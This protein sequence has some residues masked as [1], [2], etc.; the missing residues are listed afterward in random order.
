MDKD[1]DKKV[2]AL[3]P[4]FKEKINQLFESMHE[5]VSMLYE[6]A[7]HDEKTGLYNNKFFETMLEMEMEKAKRYQQKL[8]LLIIDIDFFKRINDTYGHMK[9]DELL[10][11]LAKVFM[12][13]A[14][15]SDVV[16]RFG[17]EEFII[18]LPETDL[19]KAKKF[20]ERL[21]QATKKNKML[22]GHE[23]TFSGGLT[24]YK[25]G[26]TKLKFKERAD[27][28]LYKAKDTGRDKIVAV[29]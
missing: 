29:K 27:K 8:S 17:G 19:N 20:A 6:A 3:D 14:R 24:E 7:T 9:A 1:F 10:A 21:R 28:G 4:K 11:E 26:D 16:A 13:E 5:S 15:K 12:K 18:L 22:K 2:G 25:K 23:L